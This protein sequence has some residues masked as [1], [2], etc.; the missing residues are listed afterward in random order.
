MQI[1]YKEQILLKQ[2]LIDK[3][4]N[5]HIMIFFLNAHMSFMWYK[6]LN[7]LT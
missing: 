5:T 3:F 2:G 7:K 4:Y 6:W 1:V